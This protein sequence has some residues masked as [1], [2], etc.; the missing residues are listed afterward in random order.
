[1]FSSFSLYPPPPV[2]LLFH[3]HSLIKATMASSDTRIKSRSRPVQ[4]RT[5]SNVNQ[6]SSLFHSVASHF[7]LTAGAKMTH[8]ISVN[9]R[10]ENTSDPK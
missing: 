3:L 6:M 8:D 2:R 10:A 5:H 7:M 1:M 9:A 4:N